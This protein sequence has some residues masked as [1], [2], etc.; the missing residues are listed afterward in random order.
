MH[1]NAIVHFIKFNSK[2]VAELYNYMKGMTDMK[3]A[4]FT[5]INLLKNICILMEYFELLESLTYIWYIYIYDIYM[6]YLG[7]FLNCAKLSDILYM[8][9]I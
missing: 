3:E 8:P 5:I 7:W 2:F 9:F 6:M 4:S 1:T